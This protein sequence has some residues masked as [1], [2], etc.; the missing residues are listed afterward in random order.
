MLLVAFRARFPDRGHKLNKFHKLSDKNKTWQPLQVLAAL[1][2]LLNSFTWLLL[3]DGLV[4][5]CAQPALHRADSHAGEELSCWFSWKSH[6]W[7]PDT[8][9]GTRWGFVIHVWCSSILRHWARADVPD[10]VL[11]KPWL[12]REEE[13][14]WGSSR[15]HSKPKSSKYSGNC[16]LLQGCPWPPCYCWKTPPCFNLDL[17]CHFDA[18][19]KMPFKKSCSV[20]LFLLVFFSR[21]HLFSLPFINLRGTLSWLLEQIL[22]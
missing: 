16:T 4:L 6:C 10:N 17:A 21:F 13:Q 14:Q 11:T 15:A 8:A 3:K 5:G 2:G 20:F 19:E 9:T 7:S 1:K 22:L 18:Y 12:G